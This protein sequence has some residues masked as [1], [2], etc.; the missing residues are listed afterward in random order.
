[1]TLISLHERQNI[2]LFTPL[3]FYQAPGSRKSHVAALKVSG[4]VLS[5]VKRDFFQTVYQ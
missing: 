4:G 1:M 2:V 5:S 3:H